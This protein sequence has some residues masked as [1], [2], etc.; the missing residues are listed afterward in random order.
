MMERVLV[1]GPCGAGKSTAANALGGKLGLPV[2][3][4]DQLYWRP[5]WQDPAPEEFAA[6]LDAALHAPRWI[7]DG[8][9]GGSMDLRMA[10]ADTVIYLDFPIPLCLWRT[11]SRVWRYRGRTRPDMS[12]E[13]PER[14]DLS[15]M[16]YIAAWPWTKRAAIDR[17]LSQFAGTTH[18]FTSP[19]QLRDWIAGL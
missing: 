8:N 7:I 3:H 14:F 13:C 18:T 17:R 5:G 4:L 15:F 10:H 9:Y 19:A 2:V 6:R 16:L 1:I 12:S 11:F